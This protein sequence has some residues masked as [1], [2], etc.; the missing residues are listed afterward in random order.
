M[1]KLCM[2]TT[3]ETLRLAA[4]TPVLLIELIARVSLYAY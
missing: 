2:V 4:I 1:I 3:L